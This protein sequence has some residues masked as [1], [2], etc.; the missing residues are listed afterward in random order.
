[1]MAALA[2]APTTTPAMSTTRASPCPPAARATMSV[3]AIAASAPA[4]PATGTSARR[5]VQ[6]D[7]DDRA[8]GRAARHAEQIRLG[9]PI[10]RRAL[11]RGTRRAEPRAD[12]HGEHD[13]RQSQRAHDGDVR[14]AMP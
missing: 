5:R 8:D 7:G 6:R 12:E 10:A 2:N 14:R 4:K 13:A 11:Q 1:M 3:S 9:E